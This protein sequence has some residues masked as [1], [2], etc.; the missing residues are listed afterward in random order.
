LVGPRRLAG[1]DP[2]TARTLITTLQAYPRPIR[3]GRFETY[4]ANTA[5]R[6]LDVPRDRITKRLRDGDL[7]F[8]VV[9]HEPRIDAGQLDTRPD[10]N[11]ARSTDPHP[12][13]KLS[14]S[15]GGLADLLTHIRANV[16]A[17]VGDAGFPTDDQQTAAAMRHVLALAAV[18][19]RHTVNHLPIADANRPCGS[20]STPSEP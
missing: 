12:L 2:G 13:A 6:L 10:V 16:G 5:A 8:R 3:P 20:R 17:D 9:E 11:P 7:T 14:V 19:A 4:S 18:T 1:H 15:L